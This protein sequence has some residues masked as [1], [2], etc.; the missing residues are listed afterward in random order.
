MLNRGDALADVFHKQGDYEA[1]VDLFDEARLRFP[2]MRLLA[3]VLMPNHLHL[4]LWPSDD[5]ELGRRMHWALTA[6][7][8][9]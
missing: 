3:F 9:R 6:H 1:F 4:A 2:T 5:G 7:V 8:R